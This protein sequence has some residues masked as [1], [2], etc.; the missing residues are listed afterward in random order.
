LNEVTGGPPIRDASQRWM[1]R[2]NGRDII[3]IP[4]DNT[5]VL[6]NELIGCFPFQLERL[7]V[8]D[9]D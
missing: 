4:M 5:G 1:E 3:K 8:M 6:I 9:F 7:H 2:S